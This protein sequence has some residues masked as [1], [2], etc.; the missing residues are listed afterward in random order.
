M[1][2]IY[3]AVID[4][5]NCAKKVEDALSKNS[6]VK[7]VNFDFINRR[8]SIDTTLSFDEVYRIAKKIEDD[9]V[10]EKAEITHYEFDAE[11]D[12]A[13]CAAKVENALKDNPGTESVIFDFM[14]KKLKIDTSLTIDEIISIA[15]NIEDDVEL[16]IVKEK[17]EAETEEIKEKV[18]TML[19]K[20]IIALVLF[21]PAIIFDLKYVM[22]LSYAVSGYSILWK[23][24]KN[25][26]KGKVFDENFLMS[27]ATIG[28]LVLN[29]FEEAAA[30][31]IFYLVGEYFQ[32]RAVKKSKKEIAKLMDL[33]SEVA[34]LKKGTSYIEVH[35]KAVKKGDTI[36]VLV[37]EKI[38]L[39]GIVIEGSTH[40]DTRSLTGEAKPFDANVGSKVL[41]GSVNLSSVV[42]IKTETEYENST[43]QKIISLVEKSN[44]KK[45]NSEK[46]ITKFSRYYTPAVCALA[47]LV[48]IIPP[49][50]GL[51][52]WTDWLY[53]A[54]LLLVVSCPCALVLSVPLSYFAAIGSFAKQGI[55]VKNA[56]AIQDLASINQM[57]FDKTGTLTNGEFTVQRV[58]SS[59]DMPPDEIVRIAA[60]LDQFSNHPIA[61]AITAYSKKMTYI[62]DDLSEI[63]GKGVKG[64]VNGEVYYLGNSKLFKKTPNTK[65]TLT[66][67]FLGTEDNVLGYILIG[68]KIKDNAKL[69][70]KAL[71]NIGIN[72]LI[73]L[74]GDN[75]AVADEIG[76]ELILDQINSELL[77]Q[78]KLLIVDN[79]MKDNENTAFVGDGINDAPTLMRAK[80]GISMGG[81][82]SDA[83]IEA[84]DVV[85]MNDDLSKIPTAKRIAKKTSTIVMENIVFSLLIKAVIM[86]LSIFGIANMWLAIFA[87]VGVT[88]LA[89]LNSIRVLYYRGK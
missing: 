71:K 12:C 64:M 88:I 10:L 52:E 62:T 17:N 58:V 33:Q 56:L 43:A 41:S 2:S 51:G 39:D 34:H 25:L 54:L 38:P 57:A 68:D 66:T 63:A 21:V 75:K 67:V 80:I 61:K 8:L 32:E 18:D 76:K 30:V 78:D 45:A 20:I 16:I 59:S 19:W 27:I 84:S 89:V 23:A 87:D 82:G 47:L 50:F 35:P 28:A 55:L 42:D 22:L 81:V 7:S 1:L 14:N 5:P 40:L 3:K 77:P 29:S 6:A 11:I 65:S 15:K 74:T 31:M 49:L 85:I 36:R 73:M 83:A 48:A 46:F 60:S 4:C 53:R 9:V 72:K 24:L 13:G 86:A 44:E 70:L 37:G 79:L 69:S 26:F